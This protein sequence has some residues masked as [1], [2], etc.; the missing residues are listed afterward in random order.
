MYIIYSTLLNG[1][2]TSINPCTLSSVVQSF[3]LIA[4][5]LFPLEIMKKLYIPILK[6]KILQWPFFVGIYSQRVLDHAMLHS[7]EE[8]NGTLDCM[9]TKILPGNPFAANI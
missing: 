6:L 3:F 2:G 5:Y 7:A 1:G 4:F 8:K 9:I